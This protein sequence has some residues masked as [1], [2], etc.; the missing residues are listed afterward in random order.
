VVDGIIRDDSI[1]RVRKAIS[2]MRER[3]IRTAK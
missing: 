2:R 1:E 3:C